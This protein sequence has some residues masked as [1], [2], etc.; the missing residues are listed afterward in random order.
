LPTIVSSGHGAVG[1]SDLSD[2]IDEPYARVA[3]PRA[4]QVGSSASSA[5]Q[6]CSGSAG[7]ASAGG[8]AVAASSAAHHA[9]ARPLGRARAK[10]PSDLEADDENDHDSLNQSE[11][12]CSNLSLCMERH[13]KSDKGGISRCSIG[14][15]G[16]PWKMPS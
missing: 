16:K 6:S 5:L 8:S 1:S 11:S 10:S 13:C 15:S 2:D 7:A 9:A 12:S 4:C 14:L 3:H